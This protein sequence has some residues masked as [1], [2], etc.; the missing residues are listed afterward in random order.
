MHSR[1]NEMEDRS[2][3][4]E[5]MK[6]EIERSQKKLDEGRN[7]TT[8]RRKSE[9][10]LLEKNVQLRD[11]FDSFHDGVLVLDRNFHYIYWNHAME[12][13]SGVPGEEIFRSD[14]T[15][16]EIFPHLAEQ[17]VD[18]LM[19]RAMRGEA[20]KRKNIPYTLPEGKS[21]FTNEILTPLRS[22]DGKIYGVIDIVRD[23]TDQILMEKAR[24]SIYAISEAVQSTGSLDDLYR[25]IHKTIS[26][27]MPAKDNFYIALYDEVNHSLHFPYFVDEK[28]KS[29]GPQPMGKGLTEYVLRTEEPLLVSPD[30]F[31]ELID[32]G[33]VVSIGPASIDWLGVPLKIQNKTIGVLAVQSYTDGLRF[34]E[35]EKNILQF[36]SA[37]V[38]MA[39]ERKK[40]HEALKRS[41]KKY[42]ILVEKAS[43]VIAIVQDGVLKYVNPRAA[44]LSGYSSE[45]LLDMPFSRFVHAEEIGSIEENYRLR[46]MGNKVPG[47]YE[48][49]LLHKDGHVVFV[50][51]HGSRIPFRGK[52]ADYVVIHDISERKRMQQKI[53]ESEEQYKNLVEKADI[54]IMIDDVDGKFKYFNKTFSRIFGYTEK[55]I[56]NLSI[57]SIIHPDDR[58]RVLR[59]HEDRMQGKQVKKRYEITGVRKDGTLL[60]CE[61]D[62]VVLREGKRIVGTRS[63]MWDITERKQAEVR[64]KASLKEKE[65]LLREIHHRVKNNLQIISSLLN[66]QSRNLK[67]EK[68]RDMFKESQV[69]VR[70]MA[71]VHEKLYRSE[72]LSNVDFSEYI[73][74]LAEHLF[75]VYG[76]HDVDLKIDIENV[77][78]D[79]NTAIPCGLIIS[80][81][82]SNS[83]KYAFPKGGGGELKVGLRRDSEE[84]YKLTVGDSGKGLPEDFDIKSG[85]SLGLQLVDMLTEQLNGS[86][87]FKHG[88]GAKF[89]IMF[90][91]VNL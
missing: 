54:A 76:V 16:W 69:R 37:Q 9:D 74:N 19:R 44:E 72:D 27:L 57:R 53:H 59:L 46:M 86:L 14:K 24:E 84:F 48:T 75:H 88:A 68:A 26:A 6:R 61:I 15:A 66:L 78:L 73:R 25:F 33:E 35:D 20:V 47:S 58:D 85:D 4:D 13:I 23:V 80:E 3:D 67:D 79:I 87:S 45:E 21:G 5:R 29:P 40:A 60:D 28:E 41:E 1:G 12:E 71:L 56:K 83:L 36:I 81:L 89:E 65:V 22:R 17:G 63:Y 2:E 55:D 51:I 7:S 30:K 52:P 50:E 10:D 64:L 34:K 49:R 82:I 32:R 77:F 62:V 31:K 70:S 8:I 39:I 91:P 11:V 42:R 43:D 38:A 90:K 18:K